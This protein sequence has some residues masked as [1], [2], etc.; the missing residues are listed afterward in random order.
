M[1]GISWKSTTVYLSLVYHRKLS[2]LFFTG[3]ASKMKHGS[4]QKNFDADESMMTSE[5]ERK[6][7]R[8]LSN[9]QVSTISHNYN[10]KTMLLSSDDE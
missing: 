8:K 6:H 1:L 10:E 5:K 4:R 3:G 7:T 9:Q 2:E